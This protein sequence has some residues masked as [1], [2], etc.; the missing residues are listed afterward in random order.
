MMRTHTH[1]LY[2]PLSRSGRVWRLFWECCDWLCFL[3][4]WGVFVSLISALAVALALAVAAGHPGG[5]QMGSCV[6]K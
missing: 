4:R 2:L 6:E 1:T 3:W 5:V